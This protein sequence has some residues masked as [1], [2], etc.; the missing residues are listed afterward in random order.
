VYNRSEPTVPDGFVDI[1]DVAAEFDAD[2]NMAPLME[3][4]RRDLA[5]RF[6]AD[7][8]SL[9]GLRL[10]RGWSQAR[11]ASEAQTSQSHIAR[12]ESGEKDARLDTIMRLARCL[13]VSV[14]DLAEILSEARTDR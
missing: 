8:R 7:Q 10:Q 4:A 11:L 1:D 2:P 3:Q 6:Y 5:Q 13:N 9:A 12:I 14:G